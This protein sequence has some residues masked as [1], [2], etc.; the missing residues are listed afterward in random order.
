MTTRSALAGSFATRPFSLTNYSRKVAGVFLATL[1]L[2]VLACSSA[3]AQYGGP[4]KLVIKSSVLGEDRTIL[5]RTPPGYETND[6]K[7]PVLYMTDGDAHIGHTSSTIEFLARN[8]RM[9]EL[10]VV[11][12]TNTDR[13]RDL[14]PT[15]ATGANAAQF[16]TAGGADNFL[17]FI[18]TEVIPQIEKTYRVQP[19]RI[20]A[21]HSFG[22]LFT[23][24]T[25]ITHP[26]LF[27]SYVAVSPSLQWSDEA[28]LKRAEEFFKTRKDLK[29]TLFTSLGN[30]PGDI[31][32]SFES[33]KQ[34]LASTKIKGF[35]WDAQQL[36]DEDHGSVVL[37]SHYLGMR[38]IYDGW[39]MPRDAATGAVAGGLKAADEHYKWL[40]E[41]FGYSIPTP[42][43][44]INQIGYQYLLAANP[45]REEAIAVFKTNVER[46][47]N[48]ANVYDSLAEAYEKAGQLDLATPLYEKAQAL[49]KQNN[50]P[51][52]AIYATNFAR[53]SDKLK[54]AAAAKQSDAAKQA[55]AAKKN[56]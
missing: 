15:K 48:S 29:V 52:A 46:Y 36:T 11:G 34:L 40:S 14:T 18:A 30:E 24:H 12:I 50:D 10:I 54:Q 7:Y 45:N 28:T 44:L 49:G 39:Q 19:Y 53:S 25:L 41:K 6:R 2:V 20:L 43:A 22:G 35:E 13:T 4:T 3:F 56:Q 21:G 38:K 27:N 16:P 37:R 32:K 47:P 42:E 9:S 5:V 31:G 51:N 1:V 55:E 8:G 17:K 23:V 26:E 33:F